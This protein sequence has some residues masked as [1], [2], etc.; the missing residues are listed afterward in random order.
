[1]SIE[2]FPASNQERPKKPLSKTDIDR[3]REAGISGHP[4]ATEKFLGKSR[5]HYAK[6]NWLSREIAQNFL[7]HNPGPNRGTLSGVKIHSEMLGDRTTSRNIIEGNWK[8]TDATGLLTLHSDKPEG[9]TAGGNGIGIKQTAL[10]LMRDFGVKRFEVVGEGWKLNYRM[11]KKDEHG[12]DHDWLVAERQ[13]SENSGNCRYIIETD[14]DKIKE[15]LAELPDIAVGPDNTFLKEPNFENAKGSVKW[16]LPENKSSGQGL[17]GVGRL[18][19]NGQV[20]DVSDGQETKG[21]K[22]MR[23][24]SLRLNDVRY[25]MSIDRPPISKFMVGHYAGEMV[26]AMEPKDIAEQIAASETIWAGAPKE[27]VEWGAMEVIEE[28]VNSLYW[29][30]S[31]I[32]KDENIEKIAQGLKE[33]FKIRKYLARDEKISEQAEKDLQKRGFII[34]PGFFLKLGMP[35]AADYADP[36]SLAESQK[37]DTERARGNRRYSAERYGVEVSFQ[38]LEAMGGKKFAGFI[39]DTIQP[40]AQ[41]I[42]F[43]ARENGLAMMEIELKKVLPENLLLKASL[44]GDSDDHK[45]VRLIRDIAAHGLSAETFGSVSVSQGKIILT[46][47]IDNEQKD[48]PSLLV[49]QLE[50]GN[51]PSEASILQLNINQDAVEAFQAIPGKSVRIGERKPAAKRFSTVRNKVLIGSLGAFLAAGGLYEFFSGKE[52]QSSPNESKG[53]QDSSLAIGSKSDNGE[54]KFAQTSAIISSEMSKYSEW[55]KKNKSNLEKTRY[56]QG[57]TLESL[58]SA[59]NR[60][61]VLGNEHQEAGTAGERTLEPSDKVENFEI[62]S[63]PTEKQI[64]RLEILQDAV[65]E[66]TGLRVENALFVFTGR[67]ARG[68]NIGH[69]GIG[70]HEAV[71]NGDFLEAFGTFAHEAAHNNLNANG[72]DK[73][74]IEALT[75]IFLASQQNLLVSLAK[76]ERGEPLTSADKKIVELVQKWNSK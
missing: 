22:G 64:M 70:V 66:L 54:R 37:P 69:D 10:I 62:I 24:C 2:S 61:P 60:A 27:A 12:L 57:K 31:F 28:L 55:R 41:G 1:M 46:F 39:R 75:G 32:G 48:S 20:M 51:V 47:G 72:H 14:N 38:N 35:G 52:H 18:Y 17:P 73:E 8:F 5:E 25:E 9:E 11:V 58:M 40:Y 19:I 68:V 76:S 63:Q 4:V 42:K 6:P 67:G 53:K 65:Y 44:N 49:R 3:I 21:W 26:K 74:F 43:Q 36:D 16:L 45:L 71:I 13:Q 7:D 50:R 34:C 29:K 33:Y 59:F 56:P 15:A 30:I 23:G